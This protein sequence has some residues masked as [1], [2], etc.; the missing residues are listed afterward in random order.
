[1]FR[2]NDEHAKCLEIE[3]ERYL[4]NFFHV[5]RCLIYGMGKVRL[6]VST[7]SKMSGE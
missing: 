7:G 4:A 1:M 6:E 2:S 5:C 3:S